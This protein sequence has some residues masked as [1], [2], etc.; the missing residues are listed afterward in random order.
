[1]KKLTYVLLSSPKGCF[2]LGVVDLIIC[3]FAIYYNVYNACEGNIGNLQNFQAHITKSEI[4]IAMFGIFACLT[5]VLLAYNAKK[6][7]K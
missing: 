7:T 6:E 4:Q 2:I 3:S 5:F 1:M